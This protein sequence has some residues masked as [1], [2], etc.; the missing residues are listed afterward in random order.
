MDEDELIAKCKSYNPEAQKVIYKKYFPVFFN[1]CSRF[2]FDHDD[3][4]DVLQEAFLKIFSNISKFRS[5]GSFEG[6]MKR[7]VINDALTYV[8]KKSKQSIKAFSELNEFDPNEINICDEFEEDD[9]NRKYNFT[10]EELLTA[11]KSIPENLRIVFNLAC[12][13]GYSH[14]EIASFLAISEENSRIR[15]MTA[16]KKIKMKLYSPM[17]ILKSTLI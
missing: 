2:I 3:R 7:I 13:E 8:K 17:G 14:K 1:I 6:W 9:E 5:D 12:M 15:L 4:K 16:R 10:E 11:I